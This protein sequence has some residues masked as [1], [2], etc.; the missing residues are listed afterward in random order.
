MPATAGRVRMPAGN[1]VDTSAAVNR[2]SA[3]WSSIGGGAEQQGQ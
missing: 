2:T 3:I 1:R